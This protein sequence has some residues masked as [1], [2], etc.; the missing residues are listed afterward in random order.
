MLYW[1]WDMARDRCNCYF[2]FWATFCPFT[3][4]TRVYSRTLL[5][6]IISNIF[7][8]NCWKWHLF[9]KYKQAN[10]IFQKK[11]APKKMHQCPQC[12]ELALI[13]AK[14]N[15]NLKK[16]EKR[17]GDIIILHMCTKSYD[18]MMHCSW[19]MMRNE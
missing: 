2:S 16:M 17:L 18:Q 3:P 15:Q 7:I 12:L 11:F 13:T 9:R 6:A 10:A 5:G 14:K 8:W 19:D 4:I 1:S